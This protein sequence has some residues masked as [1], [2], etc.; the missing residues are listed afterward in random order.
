MPGKVNPVMSEMLMMVCAQVIGNDAAIAVGGLSG[1]FELNVMIPVIAHNLLQS[2]DLLA[3]GATLFAERCVMG[4]VADAARCREMVE[5]SLMMVTALAPRIG[6]DKAASIAKEA[7]KK[8]KTVRELVR[9][10]GLLPEAELSRLLDP[11][12]MTEPGT[13]VEGGGAG[14]E[15]RGTNVSR[16][17]SGVRRPVN[18]AEKTAATR[19]VKAGRGSVKK[20]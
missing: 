11:R 10:K 19:A 20:R 3:R 1:N 12:R 7:Y 2:I 8:G 14:V 4:L 16:G 13:A 15:R 9:E 6:Y 5:R 17:A 18:K